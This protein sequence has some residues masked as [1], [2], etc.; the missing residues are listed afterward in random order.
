MPTGGRSRSRPPHTRRRLMRSMWP[1]ADQ[2][3]SSAAN[4]AGGHESGLTR[5]L[6][7][8]SFIR[9]TIVAFPAAGL[10]IGLLAHFMELSQWSKWAWSAATMP[11]LLIL[12]VQIV[13]SLR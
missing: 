6:G 13:G 2:N 1:E 4:G 5:S 11:V 10:A 8:Q 7:M 3:A 9:P 12:L